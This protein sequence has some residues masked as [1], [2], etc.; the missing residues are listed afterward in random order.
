[1]RGWGF[2]KSCEKTASPAHRLHILKRLL[3]AN[4]LKRL[5]LF[6]K[7]VP[8]F[9]LA[10]SRFTHT[11]TFFRY[12]HTHS[13]LVLLAFGRTDVFILLSA[14]PAGRTLRSAKRSLAFPPRSV[15][16]NALPL[17][18]ILSAFY[19]SGGRTA[20]PA[21]RLP[22]CRRKLDIITQTIYPLS[23]LIPQEFKQK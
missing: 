20:A 4:M 12:A 3:S 5:R 16:A 13:V 8:H 9:A 1:M 6:R 22:V 19:L 2:G 10:P 18:R 7:F 21:A 11:R 14:C 15:C 23:Q 17:F